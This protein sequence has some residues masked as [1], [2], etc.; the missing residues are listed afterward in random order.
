MEPTATVVPVRVP[1]ATALVISHRPP[2]TARISVAPS[3]KRPPPLPQLVTELRDLVVQ[4][5]QQQTLIPLQKL[6]RYIGFGV[7][8]SLLLGFG[9]LFLGMSGC[10]RSRTRPATRSPA[11]GRGCP[12]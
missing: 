10:G 8:G 11:T 2:P 9:V 6:G 4:Y 3:G 5:F 1:H 12:T 7:L